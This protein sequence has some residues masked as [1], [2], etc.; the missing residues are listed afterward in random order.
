M[1]IWIF[2]FEVLPEFWCVTFY[3]FLGEKFYTFANDLQGL[4]DFYNNTLSG[5]LAGYNNVRY[6]NYILLEVL[7]GVNP[8]RLNNWIISEKRHGWQYEPLKGKYLKVWT[9]DIMELITN[10]RNSLK[11]YQA[12]LGL[13]IE[14][15]QVEFNQRNLTSSQQHAL[16]QYNKYDVATT[17]VLL[18]KFFTHFENKLHLIEKNNINK[19]YLAKTDSVIV[20][21]IFKADK[22]LVPHYDQFNFS[23]HQDIINMYLNYASNYFWII[24]KFEQHTYYA[25]NKIEPLAFSLMLKGLRYDFAEGGLHAA[26]ENYISELDEDLINIDIVSNYPSLIIHY[27]LGSRS[28]YNM[29]QKM[30]QILNERISAKQSGDHIKAQYLKTM[31]VRPFGSMDYIYNDLYDPQQRLAICVSGQLIIFLLAYMLSEFSD[32]IQVNTDGILIKTSNKQRLEQVL[33]QW[34]AL[35]KMNVETNTYK[36]IYQKD[37]NNYIL[38]DDINNSKTWRVKGKYVKQYAQRF[39]D[40][41]SVNTNNSLGIIDLALVNYLVKNISIKQT[42]RQA[43]DLTLFQYVFKL[44]GKFNALYYGE[45][46]LTHKVYRIFYTTTG[47]SVFKSFTDDMGR[48]NKHKIERTSDKCLIYNDKVNHLNAQQFN[49]DYDYYEQLIQ[50]AIDLFITKRENNDLINMYP[51]DEDS[52]FLCGDNLDNETT[53]NKFYGKEICTYCHLTKGSKHEQHKRQ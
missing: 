27:N 16:I 22:K 30:E 43:T 52:C 42:L 12:Y 38:I 19:F 28:V 3:D 7:R 13:N 1:K 20:S 35:T 24:E 26:V 18:K 31:L 23:A 45:Q 11:V 2:D 41:G 32:I 51:G 53:I 14:Q 48:I 10:T 8:Y 49:L 4:K 34:Q 15:A 29:G 36:R 17:A 9:F 37:V 46:K 21:K 47:K 25:L 5:F 33:T 39:N 50:T 6:D 40:E 44:Q